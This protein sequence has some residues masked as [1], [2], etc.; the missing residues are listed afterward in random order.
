[1]RE[2]QDRL[3]KAL[4]GRYRLLREIGR[5]GA[6]IIYLA[7]DLKHDRRVALKVFRP[8]L[9][10][11]LGSDRFLRE[12]K[13]AAKLSHPH[14]LPVHDSGDAG[15]FLYYVMPVVEGHSL[16]DRLARDGVMSLAD[17]AALLHDLL[18][19]LHYA[20]QRGVVH[21]DIKPGNVMLSGRHAMVTDFGVAKAL[22]AAAEGHESDTA[23]LVLGTPAYM[24]PEQATADPD[25][26][27]RADIYGVGAL[28]YEM[29]TGR[30]PFEGETPQSLLG[31]LVSKVPDPVQQHRPETPPEL[32]QLVMKC[33][34]KDPDARW[35]TAEEALQQLDAL[36]AT[37]AGGLER[38]SVATEPPRAF[39]TPKRRIAAAAAAIVVVIMVIVGLSARGPQ[40]GGGSTLPVIAVLPF[41][42]L[43]P[44]EDEYFANGITDAITARLA[45]LGTLGVI[46][47]T[48]AMQYR[49]SDLSSR[50]IG[51]ELGADYILE[52]T[53]QRER[54]SD[55]TS[56]VR[57]IPQLIRTS[58]DTH[59]W[60]SVYDE[61]MVE[62]FRVQSE[63]AE[64]V[65][66]AMDV[67][68]AEPQRQR[69]VGAPTTNLEAY[70]FYLRGHDYL[71]GSRG[72]GDANARRIA[73][74]FFDDA[75]ALDGEFALAWAEQS[76][77][78]IWLYRHFVDHTDRRALLAKAAVDTALALAP[79]LPTAY[80]ALG[81]YYYWGP[82]SDAAR[83]L[84]EFQH[85]SEREP[86]NAYA[87]TLIAVLQ[88]A[89]G[90]WDEAV[91]NAAL[92]MELDPREPDWAVTAGMFHFL[93]RRY[94]D[95]ERYLDLALELS[96]DNA[97]AFQTKI[98]LQL[99]WR[100]D[101]ARAH[102]VA[103]EMLA[104]VTPGQLALALVEVAPELIAGGAYDSVFQQLSP[105][106]LSGPYPFDYYFTLAEFN[107]LRSRPAL[108]RAYFDSLATAVRAAP[109]ASGDPVVSMF[110]GRAYAG[111][112]NRS[113]SL[114]Q[115][116]LLE[117]ELLRANDALRALAVRVSLVWIYGML[118]EDDAAID[119]LEALLG[120]PS[121][122]S[123]T[124]LRIAA[125]PGTIRLRPRFQELVSEGA[126]PGSP[127]EAGMHARLAG[128]PR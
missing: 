22:E 92:A 91:A 4:T 19:A 5:G 20:H 112:G 35:Q 94:E 11:S 95:A 60:A 75:I 41:E 31:A 47:R 70:E 40:P 23:G 85:V 48:S 107:R 62:V 6:A 114:R 121:P 81:L 120:V 125:L 84:E 73:I 28:A 50:E 90:Q 37:P 25:I 83:A 1:M 106:S 58:D 86:N 71:E 128:L 124:Y 18:D 15:G 76:V 113:L 13:I 117:T 79:G 122:V 87:R 61:D 42:N 104:R 46:S 14:I 45:A 63:I 115:A 66:R 30:T 105:G 36:A 27:H 93:V 101:T 68:L 33:L 97:A 123:V 88:A 109:A 110:L 67:T 80:L 118:G 2:L 59:V 69:I 38:I 82:E 111:L 3:G 78:H 100:G 54:P 127:I 89:R 102:S 10:A 116:G 103:N 21:R 126:P 12:I 108:A 52:G 65:A 64:R 53:I 16:R 96:P 55:P 74:D 29:L 56:R 57:I 77:A 44:P 32:A 51:A 17:V 34:E 7:D 43:G 9:A 98:A 49:G 26:D 72:S 99:R 39:W 8:D 24:A 119:H